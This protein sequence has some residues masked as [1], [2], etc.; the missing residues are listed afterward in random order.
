MAKKV[1]ITKG[2]QTVYPATVMDAVVHPDLR[3][4]SS[5]LIEEVNVS[6]IYPTG[7]IDGTNKYTL[8]TAIAKVPASLRNVGLKC[9]FLD[10]GGKLQT[11]EYLGGAWAAGSFSQVGAGK[12]SE[13][14][15]G[16]NLLETIPESQNL[17]NVRRARP[18]FINAGGSISESDSYLYVI[19]PMNGNDI[20]VSFAGGQFLA[21]YD[22]YG[23]FTHGVPANSKKLP[24]QTG[25][26]Y[27]GLCFGKTW[28]NVAASYGDSATYTPYN[29]HIALDEFSP[30]KERVGY[31]DSSLYRT[32]FHATVAITSSGINNKI[33]DFL[34][35]KGVEI[36]FRLSGEIDWERAILSAYNEAEKLVRLQDN[37]IR[38]ELYTL[39][40]EEDYV[41]VH[42]F[43]SSPSK[44][45]NVEVEIESKGLLGSM[46]AARNKLNSGI[47]TEDLKNRSITLDKLG[48]DLVTTG[49][50]KFD[51]TDRD[52]QVGKFINSSSGTL[53]DNA[54]YIV[55]GFIPFTKE[56]GYLTASYNGKPLT[57][58]AYSILLDSEKDVIAYSMNNDSK[59]VL[60]WQEGT[61]YARFS[62]S[63][64]D[65]E[66]DIQIEE[67]KE[68]T[69][70]EAYRKVLA[71]DLMPPLS[72]TEADTFRLW[73]PG[74]VCIARGCTIEMY[75]SQV[76]WCGNIGN[77]HFFWNGV[78][79]C[80]K[81]KWS[82]ENPCQVIEF[83]L[84]GSAEYMA[85]NNDSIDFRI[86]DDTYIMNKDTDSENFGENIGDSYSLGKAM[87]K[88][89]N[90]R[91]EGKYT[92]YH[93]H[94]VYRIFRIRVNRTDGDANVTASVTFP[95]GTCTTKNIQ[96][97]VPDGTSY[98]LSLEVYDN[99]NRKVASA[100]TFVRFV[101][102]KLL[103]I[104]LLPI[105][106][107]LSTGK[108]WYDALLRFCPDMQFVG[109]RWAYNNGIWAGGTTHRH[110]GRPGV[111]PSYYIGNNTYS[112]DTY[113]QDGNDGRAQSLNPFCNPNENR[114]NISYYK[115]NYNVEYDA[116]MIFL[117]T[118]GIKVDPSVAVLQ[119]RQ[120]IDGIRQGDS[121]TPIFVV[122]TLFRGNQDGI[123]VQTGNDGYSVSATYKLVEDLKVFNL[124]VALTES[125][126]EYPN[127]YFVPVSV[128][129]DSEYNFG[130]VE[131]P[132]NPHAVQT[133]LMP[134][135]AT[136]PQNQGYEQF[137]DIMYSTFCAHLH[138]G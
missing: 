133:E 106:D 102:N 74:E 64:G 87:V 89:I 12:L 43:V 120:F 70:Y 55:S 37:I 85:S 125:L 15:L 45:G 13:L 32:E 116:I 42:L 117:G 107:S 21:A 18:G 26:V 29:R 27:A 41:S 78:G 65:I 23:K 38:D 73:L 94:E 16:E 25:D 118:N 137:A 6:K 39:M 35:R 24:F 119:I 113:G 10:D 60:E 127:L 122:N 123:G 98:D 30:V 114:I 109:T 126:K 44:E 50:N 17:I 8:E 46:V 138:V 49:K 20:S 14:T 92:A 95:G 136:H 90:E 83:T 135:E 56:M 101:R 4:D 3:V 88:S 93:P 97:V 112:Y 121:D 104:K 69:D 63:T 75:N 82:C 57:G 28:S 47:G 22:R 128:T 80:M 51:K 62:I 72:H 31:N 110:E 9:S 77:Y 40:A 54:G 19:V 99:N 86:G 52:V 84:D 59:G 68:I 5:K 71:E 132:V 7:G 115:A 34:I 96:E 53:G 111:A 100:S 2:G 61:A 134:T 130:A 103:T 76:S 58:G 36:T 33:G 91:S 131:T 48:D 105:G 11:W 129:H 1:K 81:R 79:R 108:Y 66:N 124:Q 67:G